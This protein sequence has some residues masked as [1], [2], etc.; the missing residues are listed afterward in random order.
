MST[1][2]CPPPR[3]GNKNT[4]L[5]ADPAPLANPGRPT[6]R[7]SVTPLADII[8]DTSEVI[9]DAKSAR[10]FLDSLQFCIPGEA[11]T[12]EHLSH[13]LFY[14]SQKVASPTLHSM[15]QATAFLAVELTASPIITLVQEALSSTPTNPSS[16][17]IASQ[18]EELRAIT[19][20]LDSAVN[21]WSTQQD[22]LKKTLNKVPQFDDPTNLLLMDAQIQSILE[23]VSSEH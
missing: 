11:M 12:P 10:K 23:G 22:N 17:Q 15:I 14:I 18:N 7:S 8:K 9:T 13:L 2:G 20:K 3:P 5:T 16:T 1:L 19:T 21:N 6:T 4:P